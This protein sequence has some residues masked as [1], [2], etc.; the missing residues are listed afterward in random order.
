MALDFWLKNTLNNT[1]K[2]IKKSG[3]EWDLSCKRSKIYP[4]RFDRAGVR[5][6]IKV[7]VNRR[8]RRNFNYEQELE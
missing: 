3:D 5:K 7:R 8:E 6:R 2:R 1:M 4:A